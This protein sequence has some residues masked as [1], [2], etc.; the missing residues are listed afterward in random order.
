MEQQ[1]VTKKELQQFSYIV[2]AIFL[3]IGLWPFVFGGELPRIWALAVGGLLV[4]SGIVLP[5]SLIPVHR[6]WMSL[7]H[8]LGW[9]NT[10]IILGLVFF[11]MITPMGM[12]MRLFGK[13]PLSRHF[14]SSAQS[15]RVT[16]VPREGTHMRNQF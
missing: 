13:D 4:F 12:I 6:A 15:Y 11:V 8:A 10:R 16:R 1:S 7:G 9:V 2:G 3:A 14:I 5:R